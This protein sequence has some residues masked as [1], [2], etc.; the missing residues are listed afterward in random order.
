MVPLARQ[1]P[2]SSQAGLRSRLGFPAVE[3]R[4]ARVVLV[5]LPSHGEAGEV[6]QKLSRLQETQTLIKTC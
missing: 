2:F 1:G 6:G 5:G 4:P 3:G